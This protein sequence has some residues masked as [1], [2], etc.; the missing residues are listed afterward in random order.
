[1]DLI[2]SALIIMVVGMLFTFF[3][4]SIQVVATTVFARI[5]QKYA[6][7]LPE[8]TKATKKPAAQAPKEDDAAIV[9]AIAAALHADGKL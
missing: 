6:H 2:V 5:A 7:L 9:A 3:F 8:P 4:L 1:M